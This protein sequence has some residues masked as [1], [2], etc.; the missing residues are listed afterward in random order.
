MVGSLVRFIIRKSKGS[1]GDS[2]EK[3]GSIGGIVGIICNLLLFTI[4]LLAGLL[5]GSVSIIADAFNNLSDMG[6]SLITILGFK[7][8]SK[9]ADPEHPFGHGRIEYMSA[10]IVSVLIVLVGFEVFKGGVEKII[11]PEPL[12]ADLYTVAI[13]VISICIKLWMAVFNKKLGKEINSSAIKAAS[14]DSLSDCVSTGAV[15][16]AIIVSI[17]APINIDAYMGVAV[18]LFIIYSGIKSLKETIDPL[19]GMAPDSESINQIR[20][21]VFSFPE[22]LG[23]HDMIVH[24]YGPGRSF[25]SLHVEVPANIDVL[26]CHELIDSCEKI[27]T[28]K[29]KME[30]VIHMD[31]IITDDEFTNNTREE[32]TKKITEFNSDISMHDFR[33]VKGEYN[34][35]LIFDL[36]VPNKFPMSNTELIK[37]VSEIAKD[38]DNRF[39]CVITI[40]NDYTGSFFKGNK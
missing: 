26:Y 16:I 11:N 30:A 17:I 15:L 31:P 27:I 9:P 14:L 40:D 38:I 25:V 10:A 8:S 32:L 39:N 36:C 1:N 23:I 37:K 6:S 22:F 3:A 35:N 19:L 18:S 13:L 12:N 21:I 4:K 29:I 7:L 34:I 33:V 28:S 5:S 24:N 20:D 2:R